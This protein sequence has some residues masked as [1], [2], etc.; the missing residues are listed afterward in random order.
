MVHTQ[1]PIALPIPYTSQLQ[2]GP[3]T[4]GNLQVGVCRSCVRRFALDQPCRYF[5]ESDEEPSPKIAAYIFLFCIA[6]KLSRSMISSLCS[7]VTPRATAVMTRCM[8]GSLDRR[9]ASAVERVHFGKK[10]RITA[11]DVFAEAGEEL[12][13]REKVLLYNYVIGGAMAKSGSLIRE[14]LGT[15]SSWGNGVR[16]II[17]RGSCVDSS[18]MWKAK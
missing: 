5:C 8:I 17:S 16:S 12:D 18:K 14:K 3:R 2:D 1:F 7:H 11:D 15:P 6:I 9:P 13:P 10:I 4:I